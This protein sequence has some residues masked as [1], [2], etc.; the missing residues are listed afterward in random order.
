MKKT[1]IVVIVVLLAILGVYIYVKMLLGVGSI[2]KDDFSTTTS[3]ITTDIVTEETVTKYLVTTIAAVAVDED[4][5][6][7]PPVEEVLNEPA[8]P[9]VDKEH[10]ASVEEGLSV[11]G[12]LGTA[13]EK[14]TLIGE[15][16][17]F[18]ADVESVYLLTVIKAASVPTEI[19]HVWYYNGKEM[20]RTKLP[21][22]YKR[23]RTWSYKTIRPQWIGD[24]R[25]DVVDMSGK[26][27]KSF[28]FVIR[29]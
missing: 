16:T 19:E 14:K 3:T 1:V 2:I 13:V 21:I 11:T 25:A 23:H 29:E 26:V 9:A 5:D 7:A 22:T 4:K 15:A 6:T 24:W 28:P 8:T 12:A 27:L 18:N 10:V 20:A 17:E